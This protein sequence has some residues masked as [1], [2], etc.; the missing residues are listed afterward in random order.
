VIVVGGGM[1]ELF[2]NWFDHIRSKLPEWAM[3]PHCR[4]V[5]LRRAA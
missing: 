3:N 4:K 5:P 1:S 2:S